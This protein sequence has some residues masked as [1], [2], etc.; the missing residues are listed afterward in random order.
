MS[1]EFELSDH[2]IVDHWEWLRS[3]GEVKVSPLVLLWISLDRK[4]HF[5]GIR[6]AIWRLLG[7]DRAV[8]NPNIC[9]V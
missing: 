9:N 7:V 3:G 4:M 6:G 1:T 8:K 2:C 5:T